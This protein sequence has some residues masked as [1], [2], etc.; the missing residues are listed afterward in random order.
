MAIRL[1]RGIHQRIFAGVGDDLLHTPH[2]EIQ[3][4]RVTITLPDGTRYEVPRG[5]AQIQIEVFAA[6]EVTVLR[7]EVARRRDRERGT[8]QQE[9]RP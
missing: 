3:V 5:A 2:M 4:T 9:A 1:W 7:E 6:R 8:P